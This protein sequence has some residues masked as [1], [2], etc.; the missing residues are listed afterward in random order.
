MGVFFAAAAVIAAAIHV[1]VEPT[2][3]PSLAQWAMIV[4]LGTLP[5]GV[6]LYFWDV[7]VKRGDLQALSAFSYFE[8]FIAALLVAA[9]GQGTLGWNVA[10]GGALIVGGAVLASRGLWRATPVL[11]ESGGGLGVPPPARER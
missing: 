9:L 10:L 3:A 7:G 2:V 4:A 1:A 11:G 5:M 6:A 8:P